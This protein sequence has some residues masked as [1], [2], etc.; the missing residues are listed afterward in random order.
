MRGLE[1]PVTTQILSHAHTVCSSWVLCVYGIQQTL[2]VSGR[3]QGDEVRVPDSD[4]S[5]WCGISM[6]HTSAADASGDASSEPGATV[7]SL[8]KSFD[9][10]EQS[11]QRALPHTDTH[12]DEASPHISVTVELNS[13]WDD[14]TSS[15]NI[16]RSEGFFSCTWLS[17]L[18]WPKTGQTGFVFVRH[19]WQM[20]CFEFKCCNNADGFPSDI[21]SEIFTTS[22]DKFYRSAGQKN[23]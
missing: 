1:S 18:S 19:L 15:M 4:N 22:K 23:M 9:T 12:T 17:R 11:E 14:A 13:W 21:F 7:K 16:C 2:F 5:H 6:I 3:S 8:I 20:R 10:V